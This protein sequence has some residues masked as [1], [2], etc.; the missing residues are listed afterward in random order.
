MPLEQK[1][2][3]SAFDTFHK[4]AA[5]SFTAFTQ[6]YIGRLQDLRNRMKRWTTREDSKL[7]DT[8]LDLMVTFKSDSESIV[9]L[10]RQIKE[11]EKQQARTT[12]AR[13]IKDQK[14]H[15]QTLLKDDADGHYLLSYN[16]LDKMFKEAHALLQ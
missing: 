1:L 11:H 14:K 9:G 10:R 3:A 8:D 7:T 16:L 15:S 5:T 12:L 6:K 4:R 2:V 13:I